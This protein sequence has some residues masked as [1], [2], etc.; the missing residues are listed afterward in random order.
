[1]PLKLRPT[2]LGHGGVYKEDV[3]DYSVFCGEWWHRPHMR[4]PH[5]PREAALVSGPSRQR[6]N[7]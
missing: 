1:M 4:D 2:G 3:P 7:C 6:A 5:W